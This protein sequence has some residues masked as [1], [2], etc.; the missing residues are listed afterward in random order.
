MRGNSARR[1]TQQLTCLCSP[2]PYMLRGLEGT[3]GTS[4]GAFVLLVLFLVEEEESYQ[5]LKYT[6]R[7]FHLNKVRESDDFLPYLVYDFY[8]NQIVTK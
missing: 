5:R 2:I 7:I 3:E 8:S 1:I 6:P 4:D